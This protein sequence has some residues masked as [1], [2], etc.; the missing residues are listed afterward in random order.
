MRKLLLALAAVIAIGGCM[1]I[2]KSPPKDLPAYVTVYPGASNLMSMSM[3]PMS[4]IIF[5]TTSGP[6]DV[7]TF[8]RGQATTNGLAE[9][10]M[11][12]PAGSPAEQRQATFRDTTGRELLVVIARPAPQQGATLVTLTY[13]SPPK[14][15]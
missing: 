15:S 14:T 6:D 8:Y 11:Q 3:G 13:T 4:S 2:D 7:V 12:P 1:K 5:Q 10:A 9:Q